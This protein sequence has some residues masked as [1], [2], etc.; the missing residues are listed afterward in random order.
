METKEPV[1]NK[2]DNN[3]KPRNNNNLN[4]KKNNNG[5]KREKS[6]NK[7]KKDRGYRPRRELYEQWEKEITVT[8]ETEIPEM[9]KDKVVEPR[10]DDLRAAL[11]DLDKDINAKRDE[12]QKLREKRSEAIEEDKKLREETQGSLKGL[13]KQQKDLNNDITDLSDEK[14][15][16]ETDIEKL[17]WKK[18]SVIKGIFGKKLMKPDACK[19]Q[20]SELNYRQQTEQ[21]TAN[22][23]R[24]ILKDLKE[25]ENSLPK[26]VE[27][28]QIEEQIKKVTDLKKALGRKIKAKIDEKQEVRKAIDD[29]K[30]KQRTE[31]EGKE[32]Q[33]DKKEEKEKRPKH[34]LSIKMD[35]IKKSI[36][37]LR[38]KKQALKDEHDAKYKAWRDQNELEAKIKWMK[39][40]RNILMDEKRRQDEE[41]AIKDEEERVRKEKEEIERIY[42]KPK[43]YQTQIDICDNLIGFL[44]NLKPQ[45][46]VMPDTLQKA[47]SDPIS[48]VK[49]GDSKGERYEVYTKTF[50]EVGI[51]PGQGKK[52]RHKGKKKA[53][54]THE[55]TKLT[56]TYDTLT[57]FEQIKVTPPTFSTDL[58]EVLGHLAEK[59]A[60]F[61]KISDEL[62][63]GMSPEEPDLPE[64]IREDNSE[65]ED[66]V[67]EKKP[68]MKK[69]KKVDAEDENMF[70]SL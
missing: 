34:P 16:Y 26:I 55:D 2:K 5:D 59:K 14:K 53:N 1:D 7:D 51:Q 70:P 10:N 50:E 36:D 27:V 49:A 40:Q 68:P 43:K 35:A 29:A 45:E 25:L 66:K 24:A 21:L 63:E 6:N 33:E 12:I 46:K 41:Q 8:L 47:Q 44:N 11:K 64:P 48:E 3:K 58:D 52:K 13:F 32:G 57:Y 69:Q 56:Q 31:Q 4:A 38:D 30:E 18:E 20:I 65:D 54:Q 61:V 22:E 9:P 15:L 28:D 19:R 23:E 67:K 39:K 37:D 42:G 60:Y 17:M 62:N